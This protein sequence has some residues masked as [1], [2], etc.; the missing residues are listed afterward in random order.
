MAR[1]TKILH[2]ARPHWPLIGFVFLLTT[3]SAGFAALQPWPLKLLADHV[4][5][6]APLPAALANLLG[7]WGSTRQAILTVVVAG[8]L[9]LFALTS[10][11]EA[12]VTWIWTYAGRRMVYDLSLELFARLQRRSLAFHSNN[13]VGDII[14]RITGDSWAVYQMIDTL[15]FAPLHALLITAA[16]IFLMAQLDVTLTLIALLTAPLMAGLS[17]LL[18]KPLRTAATRKREIDSRIQSHIQQTLT[19]I[20]V[21]QAFAQEDREQRRFREFTDSS[22]R[23]QQRSVLLGSLNSLSSGFITTVG[24]G[25]ILYFA[26]HQ[27]LRNPYWLGSLIVFVAYLA[28]LQDQFK[29]LAA[30]YTGAQ[31]LRANVDRINNVLEAPPEIQDRPGAAAL[32]SC[33][34]EVVLE[35]VC[36]AYESRNP[37]LRDVSV[38]AGPGQTIAIVGPTGAGKSTLVSLIPRFIDPSAGRVLID[39]H[40]VRDLQL[41]T[42]RQQVAILLQEPFLFPFSVADNIAYGRPNATRAEIEA[43]ARIANADEFIVRLP[44]QY[45]TL[46]GEHGATLSGGERQRLAI[47]RALLKD[48]PILILDEPTSALDVET[49]SRLLEALKKLME[50][51]T[52]FIIAHRLSTARRADCIIVVEDGRITERGSHEELLALD[53]AYSRFHHLQFATK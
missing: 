28:R 5:G 48:A 8:G 12:V 50:G 9:L 26:A 10:I 37:V 14:S 2:F 42:V 44:S 52:T 11:L 45:D 21:V 20:P 15:V 19:G 1:Y 47:A 31:S 36:F 41:K 24:T 18:G 25:V 46:L 13:S 23:I 27:V 30:V 4:L 51:R 33:R 40:D 7:E 3:L 38:E 22:I 34:G 29:I 35:N 6:D 49:E 16:M 39:G 53:G 32:K 43:A 17:M